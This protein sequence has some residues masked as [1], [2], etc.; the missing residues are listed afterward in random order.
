MYNK[1]VSPE[2]TSMVKLFVI[3]TA[4]IALTNAVEIPVGKEMSYNFV[5][6]V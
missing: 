4:G 5:M 1:I 2:T 6:N 3:L